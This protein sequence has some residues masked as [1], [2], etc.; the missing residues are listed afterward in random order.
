MRFDRAHVMPFAIGALGA[1][2][3]L[4]LIALGFGMRIVWVRSYN[5]QAA[6]EYLQKVIEQQQAA[7][8]LPQSPTPK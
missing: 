3:V 1:L 8:K 2:V 7:Q 4:A 5:G 6:Y